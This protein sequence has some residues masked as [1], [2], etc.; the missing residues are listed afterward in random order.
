MQ[1]FSKSSGSPHNSTKFAFKNQ[2]YYTNGITTLIVM[3]TSSIV[4]IDDNTGDE[5]SNSE[6][7][8]S[9]NSFNASSPKTLGRN[10]NYIWSHFIDE[11]EAKTGGYRKARCRYC[12]M[13]LSYAKISMMYSHIANQCDVVVTKNPAARIDTIAKLTEVDHQNQSPKCAKRLAQ[14]NYIFV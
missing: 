2:H 6:L 7:S 13:L 14:V 8:I 3:A 12:M 5:T 4:V 1:Q 9:S 11:G 10:R